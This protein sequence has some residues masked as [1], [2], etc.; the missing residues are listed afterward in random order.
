MDQSDIYDRDNQ[1]EDIFEFLKNY[2]K[3]VLIVYGESGVGKSEIILTSIN[4]YLKTYQYDSQI[5]E[6]FSFSNN[7]NRIQEPSFVSFLKNLYKKYR[8]P[9][10]EISSAVDGFSGTSL[11]INATGTLSVGIS[12]KEPDIEM[13]KDGF[14]YLLE[15]LKNKE[16]KVLYISNVELLTNV[17]DA[18]IIKYLCKKTNHP[19]KIILELG[20]LNKNTQQF[21]INQLLQEEHNKVLTIEKFNEMRTKGLYSFLNGQQSIPQSLYAITQG[22][23]F[24]I[25]HFDTNIKHDSMYTIVDS[26]MNNLDMDSLK[27]LQYIY[28]LGGYIHIDELISLLNLPDVE[29][30]LELLCIKQILKNTNNYYS[31]FHIFFM[32]YFIENDKTASMNKSRKSI[33][34]YFMGKSN[35]STREML[36]YLKQLYFLD[37]DNIDIVTDGWKIFKYLYEHQDYHL[38]LKVLEIILNI[39]SKKQI[40]LKNNE[41]IL[42]CYMQILVLR[43]QAQYINVYIQGQLKL[44]ENNMYYRFLQAQILYQQNNF[45]ESNQLIKKNFFDY[46]ENKRLNIIGLGFSISNYIA[47][48]H[49]Q[50]AQNNYETA[51]QLA[52]E[53]KD[54]YLEF[55][56][57]RFAS[58]MHESWTY[59]ITQ[60]EVAIK[61]HDLSL[62]NNTRAKIMHNLGLAKILHTKGTE[63]L[64]E[65]KVAGEYFESSGSSDLVYNL[66]ARAILEII[67]FQYDNAK[68][69]LLDS[70]NL[71]NEQYDRFAI[72]SNLGNVALLQ[73]HY[74][75]AKHYYEKASSLLLPNQLSHSLNNDPSV[76]YMSYYNL[77]ILYSSENYWDPN[78]ALG[79]LE[80]IS[81]PKSMK[82]YK[83]RQEKLLILQENIKNNIKL[84]DFAYP[85]GNEK[86]WTVTDFAFVLVKLHF[87]DFNLS[88]LQNH[89]IPDNLQILS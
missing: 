39:L 54:K 19:I 3:S 36:I 60:Y 76:V 42:L 20:T 89:E 40:C 45:G 52:R 58:K 10:D 1:R 33:V 26:K 65:L 23:A 66:N 16:I 24:F 68:K 71:C 49:I 5:I 43:N 81:I 8:T 15:C 34:N 70:I 72:Y 21:G 55:E 77:A 87:Y 28:I 17:A 82:Y 86:N 74:I 25:V 11:S 2:Q 6:K 75:D 83:S 63:G 14:N 56:L 79:F 67:N 18:N 27:V 85:S 9:L 78:K 62:Y 46:A 12:Y 31:F 41:L 57:I 7:S 47:L 13:D 50:K 51:L 69:I 48:G 80:K 53:L 84:S 37:N 32:H 88:M 30:I 61:D 73:K 29:Y 64:E 59:G 44:I 22:N 38:C 4:T 35:L